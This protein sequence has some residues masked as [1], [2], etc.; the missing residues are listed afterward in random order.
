MSITISVI[1]AAIYLFL[2]ST[3]ILK[4]RF[5]KVDGFPVKLFF[6]AFYLQ[7][8]IAFV[9]YLLY[10]YHYP[11]EIGQ[12]DTKTFYLES[13][14]LYNIAMIAPIDYVRLCHQIEPHSPEIKQ[15]ILKFQYWRK[16]YDSS[17]PNDTRQ[18]LIYYSWLQVLACYSE[19][20]M[21]L[22]AN[23]LSFLGLFALFK[24]FLSLHIKPWAAFIACFCIPSVLFWTSG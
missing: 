18:V 17:A 5:F 10:T 16:F 7:M 19:G 8:G 6:G 13:G 9:F 2:I 15:E 1:L 12:N 3:W 21:L 24:V 22:L 20:L 11:T 23:F 14:K 4:G